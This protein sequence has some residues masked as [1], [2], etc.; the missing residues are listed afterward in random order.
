MWRGFSWT[1]SPPVFNLELQ[2][3][4][5]CWLLLWPAGT[6]CSLFLSTVELSLRSF[7][8]EDDLNWKKRKSFIKK[9]SNTASLISMLLSHDRGVIWSTSKMLLL[10]DIWGSWFFFP[11]LC[12]ATQWYQITEGK[13]CKHKWSVILIR[14]S[15]FVTFG[16]CRF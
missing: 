12:D 2:V 13:L 10:C 9:K 1:W 5:G 8:I 3:I 14:Y 16:H 11:Y 7:N 6:L 4:G 15:H